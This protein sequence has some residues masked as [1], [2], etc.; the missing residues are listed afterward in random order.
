MGR[1][2]A[3][4]L[5]L[6]L[7]LDPLAASP[8]PSQPARAAPSDVSSP[9]SCSSPLV[10]ATHTHTIP[11]PASRYHHTATGLTQQCLALLLR[12]TLG[13]ALPDAEEDP[14]RAAASGLRCAERARIHC[15]GGGGGGRAECGVRG[16]A[17]RR[18]SSSCVAML[19][20]GRASADDAQRRRRPP[21][22]RPL[23]TRARPR[24]REPHMFGRAPLA[25]AA[26]HEGLGEVEAAAAPRLSGWSRRRQPPRRGRDERRA[27]ADH[28]AGLPLQARASASAAVRLVERCWYHSYMCL[29][30]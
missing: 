9:L 20:A 16:R 6:P 29:Y 2:H 28:A 22:P 18:R 11:T 30:R 19:L 7:P 12:A 3:N 26:A 5:P 1:K 21:P 15:G 17:T 25:A 8:C 14:R 10:V 4:N 23:A 24:R 13:L 27:A